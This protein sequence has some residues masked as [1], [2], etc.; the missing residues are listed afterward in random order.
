MMFLLFSHRQ[1]REDDPRTSFPALEAKHQQAAG[2][3]YLLRAMKGEAGEGQRICRWGREGESEE[4]TGVGEDSGGRNSG[5][6]GQRIDGWI[7][8]FRLGNT[9]DWLIG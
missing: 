5:W 4:E 8:R 3:G 2:G 9:G 1:S 7:R 6:R